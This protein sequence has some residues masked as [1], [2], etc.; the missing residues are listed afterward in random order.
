M[1][2]SGKVGKRVAADGYRF[3]FELARLGASP[4][5]AA[6]L[7]IM[8]SPAQDTIA[9]VTALLR[10]R[11]APAMRARDPDG[12]PWSSGEDVPWAEQAT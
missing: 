3:G 9:T 11:H 8:S 10:R 4:I 12:D 1:R 6:K 2:Y 5:N 7:R